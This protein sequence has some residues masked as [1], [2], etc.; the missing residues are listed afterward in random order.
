M[1][2][3]LPSGETSGDNVLK[4]CLPVPF[5]LNEFTLP[6]VD[7]NCRMAWSYALRGHLA[8]VGS[9]VLKLKLEQSAE[10]RN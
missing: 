1:S 7:E 3:I 6:R 10:F 4:M 8:P 5:K 2:I 9:Q